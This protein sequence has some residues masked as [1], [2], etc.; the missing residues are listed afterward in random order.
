MLTEGTFT[1]LFKKC[2][3]SAYRTEGNHLIQWLTTRTL[4]AVSSLIF[5]LTYC[6][7]PGTL[8][9]LSGILFPYM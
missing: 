8:L 6:V 7:M 2:S 1:H 9:K 3:P 5:Y 4:E